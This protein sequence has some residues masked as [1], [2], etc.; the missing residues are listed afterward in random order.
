MIFASASCVRQLWRSFLTSV[1]LHW[2][3]LF[4]EMNTIAPPKSWANSLT[5]KNEF[6][7]TSFLLCLKNLPWKSFGILVAFVNRKNCSQPR[8]SRVCDF[9]EMSKSLSQTMLIREHPEDRFLTDL[10]PSANSLKVM[11]VVTASSYFTI[12][13][14]CRISASFLRVGVEDGIRS[15]ILKNFDLFSFL[16]TFKHSDRPIIS[17][18]KIPLLI[19]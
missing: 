15:E 19:C 10:I 12:A 16:Q 17:I 3:L 18:F 9:K 7:A 4:T 1:E 8:A 2:T 6:R 5:S 13:E 14:K 11:A